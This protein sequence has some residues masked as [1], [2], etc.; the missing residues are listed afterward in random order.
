[1]TE[2]N[3]EGIVLR[4]IPFKENDR[5][6]TVFSPD[7]GIFSLY[8]RGLS[9]N[10]TTLSNLCS[11]FCKGE[12]VFRKGR[13][14]LHRFVDGTILDLHLELR[15]SYR[16]MEC[17]GKML[18]AIRETQLPGKGAEGLYR[19]LQTFLKKLP[20]LP[21]PETA[22]TSFHLKLLK[23]EGQLFIQETCGACKEKVACSLDQGE[24][25]CTD[26]MGG[27]GI[28][29]LEDEWTFL[30]SLSDTRSF[31]LI[32]SLE[33]PPSFLKSIEQALSQIAC[34]T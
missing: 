14:D 25:R 10:K 7:K 30:R 28:A 5:I 26:C 16:H 6:L 17:G 19:L 3:T 8:V 11:P 4:A 2:K 20:S 32:E 9:K 12:F 13:N 31:E 23:H 15:T 21:Y 22:W 34:Q 18:Q 24:S 27:L 33:L 1:M 29:F